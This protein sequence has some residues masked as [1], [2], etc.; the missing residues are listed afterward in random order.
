[1]CLDTDRMGRY[2]ENAIVDNTKTNTSYVSRK[3][4]CT[5]NI[6][7]KQIGQ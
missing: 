4:K 6:Y 2:Y 5:T 7:L 3:I 1:M